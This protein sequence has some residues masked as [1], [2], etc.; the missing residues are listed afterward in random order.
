MRAFLLRAGVPIVCGRSYCV[1]A[2][3]LRAGVPIVCWRS[4]CVLAFLLCVGVPIACGR[5]YCVLAFLLRAGVPIA[6]G[7]PCCQRGVENTRDKL[8]VYFNNIRSI[9]LVKE[10][11]HTEESN[12]FAFEQTLTQDLSSINPLISVHN[13]FWVNTN[14]GR[15][16]NWF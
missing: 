3:L 2:F 6:G 8:N 5:S 12:G 15:N 13:L 7:R 1:L 16:A 10:I 9:A 4:Y 14:R 11:H